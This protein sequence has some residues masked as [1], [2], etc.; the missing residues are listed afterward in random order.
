M[1][2]RTVYLSFRRRYSY[3]LALGLFHALRARG[4]DVY[5]DADEADRRDTVDLAEIEARPHFLILLTPGLCEALQDPDD[6]MRREIDHAVHKRRNIIP[7][8]TNNFSF[9]NCLV[10][11][12]I[13]LLRRYR[14][15]TLDPET[16]PAAAAALD[17]QYLG[18]QIFGNLVSLPPDAC[19]TARQRVENVVRQPLP[20][21]AA[22]RAE[23]LFNHAHM[24]ARQ[25]YAGKLADLDDVL[26][27]NPAHVPARFERALARRRIGDEAGAVE[28]Y[29][30]I[31]RLSPSFYKAYNDRAELYFT[32]GSLHRALA[33][34]EQ[35][36]A[37]HADDTMALAGKA[38]TLH[39]LGQVDE[40]LNLWK[41][42]VAEDERF[43]DPVWVGRELRLP[44][45]MIDEID[46]LTLHLRPLA[47]AT[48][49]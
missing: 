9:H 34:Y 28:D 24:R 19:V 30:E 20:G 48:D 15:L 2:D 29:N 42:L 3:Y 38:V 45:A 44:T 47:N 41:P 17:A 37:L 13:N 1:N 40:A 43:Y 31:L 39:A 21:D 33:D 7:L 22:L 32:R 5:M 11:G 36:T 26:R 6:P 8:L 12:E 10:S 23:V 46:R 14:S 35:A 4:I 16:L 27:L 25:D 18:T 49:D